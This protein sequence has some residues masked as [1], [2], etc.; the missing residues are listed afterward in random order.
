M[1]C[2]QVEAVAGSPSPHRVVRRV[3]ERLSQAIA[4]A[5]W[6]NYTFAFHDSEEVGRGLPAYIAK[7]DCGIVGELE[8]GR[9]RTVMSVWSRSISNVP[10]A[11]AGDRKRSKALRAD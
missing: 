4:A 1:A 3:A 6:P 7:K 9:I 8:A 11:R 10:F 2:C 5:G